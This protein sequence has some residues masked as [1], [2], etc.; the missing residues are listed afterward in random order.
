ML[1]SVK[2][3]EGYAISATDGSI[4]KE[5]DFYFDDSAWVVRYLVVDA[6]SWL[7]D[8]EVLISPFSVGKPDWSGK[9]VPVSL[10]R[11]QVKNSPPIDTDKP[12]S[13]QHEMGY[14]GYY[15]YPNYW[16]G[17]GL[18][19]EGAYPGLMLSMPYA[20]PDV[21]YARAR[22]ANDRLETQAVEERLAESDRHLRSCNAVKG[23]HI[24]ATDGEIGHVQGFLMDEFTW[25]IRYMVVDTSNWWVGHQVL[26]APEWIESV[27]WSQSRVSIN[28]TRRSIQD[29]P[30][31][32]PDMPLNRQEEM[33]IYTHY[34]RPAYWSSP[35]VSSR[36][37]P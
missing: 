4:G 19:G 9:L 35:D 28:L 18:W 17:T 7:A 5:K 37:A 8:R 30:V 26:V 36:L 25:A 6:G 14:L 13:R 20:G 31:Y 15:N 27:S 23:Y 11:E 29:A 34:R 3:L 10:T 33:D 16:G 32:D 2:E 1:R 22:I 12:V 24:L 21:A